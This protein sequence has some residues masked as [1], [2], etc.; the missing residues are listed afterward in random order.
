MIEW[1]GI[2]QN[3]VALRVAEER[4]RPIL[5]ADVF[6]VH[7]RQ[8]E[9]TARRFGHFYIEF[10]GYRATRH[11]ARLRVRG[12][13]IGSPPENISRGLIEEK[14]KGEWGLRRLHPS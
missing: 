10:L 12:K 3:G 6:R 4:D 14:Q 13:R 11:F 5:V 1:I 9:K 7:K 8:I 2:I